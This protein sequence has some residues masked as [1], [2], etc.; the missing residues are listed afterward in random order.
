VTSTFYYDEYPKWVSEWNAAGHADRYQGEFWTLMADRTE[1]IYA[2]RDDRPVERSYKQLGRV[3][4]HPLSNDTP[5]DYYSTL[6]FTPMGDVLTLD[7]AKEL[8]DRE[9]VGQGDAIDV[10]AVS[11]SATDYLGHAFG[12]N[13]LEMEDNVLRLQLIFGSTPLQEPQALRSLRCCSQSRRYTPPWDQA[14]G[15]AGS[16]SSKPG[17]DCRIIRCMI[18]GMAPLASQLKIRAFGSWEHFRLASMVADIP[19][20]VSGEYEGMNS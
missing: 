2:E 20:P 11:L 1:Y 18:S 6:R 13:S 7:F 12:P 19:L 4:P 15:R 17:R 9:A 8:V 14:S 16:R 10:L 5:K 3:F